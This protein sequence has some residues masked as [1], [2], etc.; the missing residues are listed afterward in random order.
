MKIEQQRKEIMYCLVEQGFFDLEV[1][2]KGIKKLEIEYPPILFHI[3]EEIIYTQLNIFLDEII[4][5]I[6]KVDLK[7]KE[8]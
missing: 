2:E 8:K 1:Y 3:L 7:E 5:I 4:E 6:N